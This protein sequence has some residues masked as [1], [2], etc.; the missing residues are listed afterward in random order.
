MLTEY[1]FSGNTVKCTYTVH[2][3]LAPAAL[4]PS[5]LDFGDVVLCVYFVIIQPAAVQLSL[6]DARSRADPC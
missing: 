6:P 3:E 2:E 4:L 5:L 1:L